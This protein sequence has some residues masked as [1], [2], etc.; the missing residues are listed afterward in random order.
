MLAADGSDP[1]DD[2]LPFVGRRQEHLH[3]A[4]RA[5]VAV[6]D[7]GAGGLSVRLDGRHHLDLEVSGDRV[8]AVAQVGALRST[9]GEATVAAGADVVLE[10]RAE[11]AVGHFA[12]TALGP[13]VL[14]AGVVGA[15]GFTELGRL[16]GRYVSTEVAGG[17]TGRMLG[18]WCARDRLVVR[19]FLYAGS[20]D[21]DGVPP[22]PAVAAAGS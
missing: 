9:L 5:T 4:V 7:D 10:I 14:V 20:D 22:F 19:S 16:D 18:V 21:A 8:R 13:D 6:G 2:D 11:A 3:A 15:D 12:S 17:F 1:A